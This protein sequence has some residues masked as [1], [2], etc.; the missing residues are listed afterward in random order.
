MPLKLFLGLY[1]CSMFARVIPTEASGDRSNQTVVQSKLVLSNIK[2]HLTNLE[3]GL[4]SGMSDVKS[5]IS[6]LESLIA[7]VSQLLGG[8]N[9]TSNNIDNAVG[10]DEKDLVDRVFVIEEAERWKGGRK[11]CQK[12]GGDLVT[13]ASLAEQRK[14]REY[15]IRTMPRE[16]AFFVGAIKRKVSEE[17]PGNWKWIN[18]D[19]MTDPESFK[20][21]ALANGKPAPKFLDRRRRDHS[22]LAI[23]PKAPYFR[24]DDFPHWGF[25]PYYCRHPLPL[26]CAKKN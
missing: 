22:C 2:S 23:L 19:G 12:S 25:H 24:Y 13:L 5:Q 6:K 1:L 8:N 4:K 9:E 26:V 15:L 16:R 17:G 20:W 7:N 18:G 10:D 11:T 21:A 3:W 14:L